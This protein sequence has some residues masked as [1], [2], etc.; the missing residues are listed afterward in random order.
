MKFAGERDYS[1][2]SF[3]G[4]TPQM[5]AHWDTWESA[6]ASKGRTADRSRYRVCRDV[7]IAEPDAEATRRVLKTAM[8]RTWHENLK[9]LY[10]KFGPFAGITTES[11]PDCLHGDKPDNV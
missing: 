8:T 9:E 1:P 11:V 6:M 7:F 10:V 2:I 4:G 5:K 3:F